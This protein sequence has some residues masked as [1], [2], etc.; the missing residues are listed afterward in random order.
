MKGRCQHVIAEFGPCSTLWGRIQPGWTG[1]YFVIVKHLF[2]SNL[3]LSMFDFVIRVSFYPGTLSWPP[4]YAV[5][6]YAC[7]LKRLEPF[8]TNLSFYW[9]VD[10]LRT[11]NTKKGSTHLHDSWSRTR[12]RQHLHDSW[13][14]TRTRQLDHSIKNS[15]W[16]VLSFT[17]L[18]TLTRQ[19]IIH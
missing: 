7:V 18:C 16:V 5:W 6:V 14:R 11:T 13:S 9:D 3:S 19:S 17:E 15:H 2:P 8:W 10:R 4:Y 12:T 1:R